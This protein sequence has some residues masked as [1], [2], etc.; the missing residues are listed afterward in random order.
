MTRP[1]FAD[2]EPFGIRLRAAVAARIWATASSS[3]AI[4]REPNRS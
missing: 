2:V 1:D 3:T 4:P